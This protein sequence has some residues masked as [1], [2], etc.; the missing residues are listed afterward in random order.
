MKKRTRTDDRELRSEYDFSKMPGGVRGKY[1][2]ESPKGTHV[3]LLEDD[4]AAAFPS[5][6]AVNRALR[7][8]LDAARE[9]PRARSK[10]RRSG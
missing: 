4:V 1:A 7:A 2:S 6:Q 5:D 9:L 8:I 3:A 10:K